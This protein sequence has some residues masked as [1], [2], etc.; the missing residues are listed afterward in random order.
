MF[1]FARLLASALVDGLHYDARWRLIDLWNDAYLVGNACLVALLSRTFGPLIVV[2]GVTCVMALSL[3]SYPQL[4][5]R[6]RIV[7]A[8]LVVAKVLG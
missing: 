2:P 6:A 5:D 3:T 7:I 1:I 8:L 4:I